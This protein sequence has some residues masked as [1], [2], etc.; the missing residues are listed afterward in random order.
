MDGSRLRLWMRRVAW[1]AA[2]WV[3]GVAG[4]GVLA[5]LLKLFMR[6]AG[7]SG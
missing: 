5:A 2:F 4:L 7:L 3:A 6:A 1:L